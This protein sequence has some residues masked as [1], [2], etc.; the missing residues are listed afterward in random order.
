MKMDKNNSSFIISVTG[1]LIIL[2]LTLVKLALSKQDIDLGELRLVFPAYIYQEN[3]SSKT[4]HAKTLAIKQSIKVSSPSKNK[5]V[6]YKKNQSSQ[7]K[8]LDEFSEKRKNKFLINQKKSGNGNPIPELIALLH[9]SIQEHQQYPNNALQMEQEGK[10][11]LMFVLHPNGTIK[12]LKVLSSSGT[13]TL[14]EAAIAAVNDAVPFKGVDKY[15]TNP[16]EYQITVA[17]ELR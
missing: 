9:A 7:T 10:T 12:N 13:P 8:N 16:Q 3:L 2:A 1:H 5:I 11:T 15:L 14:D 4:Q 17:F 6:I